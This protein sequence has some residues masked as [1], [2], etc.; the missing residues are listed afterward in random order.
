MLSRRAILRDWYLRNRSGFNTILYENK[1]VGHLNLLAFKQGFLTR[2]IEGKLVEKDAKA[3]DIYPAANRRHLRFS[4]LK[5]EHL[6]KDGL[7]FFC[8]LYT[9]LVR[10]LSKF[11]N[12]T[13]A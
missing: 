7:S 5:T 8:I 1:N 9:D 4:E 12:D 6:R 3:A 13:M 11:R 10:L 2:F